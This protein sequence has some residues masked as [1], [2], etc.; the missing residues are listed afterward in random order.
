[1]Y[2]DDEEPPRAA[3]RGTQ[4][5]SLVACGRHDGVSVR[6]RDAR[7]RALFVVAALPLLPPCP[8]LLAEN[9]AYA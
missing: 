9:I 3:G 2:L 1:M 8:T 4:G 7:Q 6:L 5:L